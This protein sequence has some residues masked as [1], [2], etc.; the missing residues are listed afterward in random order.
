[1]VARNQFLREP[2][3]PKIGI[4]CFTDRIADSLLRHR[5]VRP[6]RPHGTSIC[7]LGPH[8]IPR[9]NFALENVV[10]AAM[11]IAGLLLQAACRGW[12]AHR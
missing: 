12:S 10:I 9:F 5:L 7:Y 4:N 6:E 11:R 2:A 8:Q 1:M 3:D